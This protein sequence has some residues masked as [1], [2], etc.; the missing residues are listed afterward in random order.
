MNRSGEQ[1]RV[2]QSRLL[3][4]GGAM[5]AMTLLLLLRLVY[6][7]MF[8]HDRY[9]D[10]SQ[11]NRIEIL[12]LP[13]VRGSI[14]D[15]N[16]TVLAHSVSQLDLEVDASVVSTQAA[17]ALLDEIGRW[18][19]LSDTGRERFLERL[20]SPGRFNWVTLKSALTREEVDRL[21]VN[22]DR[23]P[24]VQIVARLRRDYPNGEG[25][26][27]VVGYL[28][29]I[30][31]E[32]QAR[33]NPGDYRGLKQIGKLGLELEYESML[34]GEPGYEEV[35]VNA[36][37]RVVRVLDQVPPNAGQHLHLTLD[38][39]LQRR[40][41]EELAPYEGA[42]VALDPNTGAVL[43]LASSPS[44]DPSLFVGGI[45][46]K[47]YAELRDN[48]ERP[49]HHRA[50]AGVYAPGSTMKGLF[51]LA[52]FANGHSNAERVTCPGW[53][54][55]PGHTHRYRDWKRHGHG[56]VNGH[57]AIVE[58]CDVYFYTLA[59]KLGIERMYTALDRYGVGKTTGIDLPG[60]RSGLMPS[61]EWKRR[62]HGQAW[63]PGETVI[64][65]IGQGFMLTTPLQLAALTAT[66][67]NGGHK[68][69]PHL[70]AAFEEPA[71]QAR[72]APARAE[73]ADEPLYPADHLAVVVRAMRDVVHGDRGTARGISGSLRY[74]IAGK[75][76]TAQVK[77]IAQ[78]EE[79]DEENLPKE[80]IDHS[81]FIAF[82]PLDD[83]QIAIAVVVEHGGSGA[84]VAAPIARRLLD[85]YLL[86]RLGMFA[87]TGPAIAGGGA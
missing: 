33:L 17:P 81:L 67:A 24:G 79:Y 5:L 26:G 63:F 80:Y 53:F 62:V 75:T 32:E 45:S 71:S 36:H 66:L 54:S 3:W 78:G 77:S 70:L 68:I 4:L 46:H 84:R 20:R 61:P 43:A 29:R 44:Y 82:A 85:F 34:R 38:L 30:N 14:F 18:V 11:S 22:L 13:P 52:G 19:L 76:G 35:E 65:G 10:F 23:Y 37:G 39:P 49:L 21:A 83:P 25:L 57:R 28:G 51:L 72:I 12:P 58:S 27:A 41:M 2:L 47:D 40:A 9:T 42:V 74:R 15:R 31:T 6:L 16:G 86:E 1:R 73:T 60:E 50:V 7:Q 64:A 48:P 55:L 69:G 87:E 59:H 56:S 8:E